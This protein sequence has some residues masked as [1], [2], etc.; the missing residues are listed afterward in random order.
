[1]PSFARW[2]LEV[3]FYSKDVHK[4]WLRWCKTVAGPLRDTIRI[5]EDFSN[6]E[7]GH[8]SDL[9]ASPSKKQN[10]ESSGGI[11]A[12]PVDY[13]H[14]KSHVEKAKEVFDFELEGSCAICQQNLAHDGGVYT[15][16]PG[17]DCKSVTHLSCLS[18]HFLAGESEALVPITGHCP[19]C[20]AELNW[21]DVVKELSLRMRGEK[22][23]EQLLKV[24]KARKKKAASS[25]AVVD[26]SDEEDDEEAAE[27]MEEM[28]MLTQ[29]DREAGD[30]GLDHA[31]NSSDDN[32]SELESVIGQSVKNQ[33]S[34]KSK[35]TKS[36]ATK[37]VI[38]DSDW[39]DAIEL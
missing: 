31:W 24:K 32:E 38:Q 10:L 27:M 21:V 18:E 28:D 17:S 1:M 22:E 6:E 2:P 11:H 13:S 19:G 3:H 34:P 36:K 14:Q 39:D 5:V 7:A 9:E 20:K 12:L 15:I 16:C 33:K 25:Q 8:S 4:L 37:T 35:S 26:V 29:F 30:L 23:V